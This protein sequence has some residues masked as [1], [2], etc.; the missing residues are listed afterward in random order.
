MKSILVKGLDKLDI[1]KP[2]DRE[3]QKLFTFARKYGYFDPEN[4][5]KTG[6]G[7]WMN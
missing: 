2:V 4:H 5:I 6:G 7:K 1:E 3:G